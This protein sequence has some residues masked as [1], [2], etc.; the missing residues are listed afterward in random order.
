MEKNKIQIEITNDQA[1]RALA[2]L[3]QGKYSEV[4]DVISAIVLGLKNKVKGKDDED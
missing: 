3:S 4:A 2:V 1:R